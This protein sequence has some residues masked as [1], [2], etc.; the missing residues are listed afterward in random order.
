[1]DYP[2]L[3]DGFEEI[4]LAHGGKDGKGNFICMVLSGVVQRLQFSF[5]ILVY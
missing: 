3:I 5:N 1:V 4:I 2:D